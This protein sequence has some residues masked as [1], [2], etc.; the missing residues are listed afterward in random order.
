MEVWVLPLIFYIYIVCLRP[1]QDKTVSPQML[2]SFFY[3]NL[4]LTCQQIWSGSS[5]SIIIE[6]NVS[7]HPLIFF[8]ICPVFSSTVWPVMSSVKCPPGSWSVRQTLARVIAS[9][10]SAS[11]ELFHRSAPT[12]HLIFGESLFFSSASCWSSL[13]CCSPFRDR[14]SRVF[15]FFHFVSKLSFRS[16]I[17][18]DKLHSL[19][20]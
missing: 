14:P 17:K 18:I 2:F 20:A 5:C 7:L 4:T 15:F 10:H 16:K 11:V 9:S 12:V 13:L 19:Q 8:W 6:T 3:I 1:V